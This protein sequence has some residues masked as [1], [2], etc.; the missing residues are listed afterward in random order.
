MSISV[1]TSTSSQAWHVAK[2]TITRTPYCAGHQQFEDILSFKTAEDD[3]L[4]FKAKE[5]DDSWTLHAQGAGIMN[6]SVKH[7]VSTSTSGEHGMW[8]C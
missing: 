6:T 2:L 7:Q 8:Q 5:E 1:S 3:A 4:S